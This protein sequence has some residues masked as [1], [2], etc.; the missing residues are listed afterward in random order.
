MSKIK[1]KET[2]KKSNPAAIKNKSKIHSRKK[3]GKNTAIQS[4]N[5]NITKLSDK[6][7][8]VDRARFFSI[9]GLLNVRKNL[10]TS[11]LS[12]IGL[13][14]L[15]AATVV[16]I[17]DTAHNQYVLTFFVDLYTKT[18]GDSSEQEYPP[19]PTNDTKP[20]EP[21]PQNMA[22]IPGG[23]FWMGSKDFNHP[24]SNPIHKV[25]VDA[26][27][28][29]ETEVTN[30]MWAE[31]VEATDY[32]TV[33]ERKPD[34]RLF[35][36]L[37]PHIIKNKAPFSL[38]FTPPPYPVKDLS[39]HL[40]W[41]Q[42]VDGA[43]WKHPEGPKSDIKE[44]KAHPVVQICWIDAV[45]Y[46]NWR[47]QKA[48][49]Q[50]CYDL[51]LRKGD[52]SF[53]A[54]T[55]KEAAQLEDNQLGD[56]TVR[57]P[58]DFG[59]RTGFRLPTEAEWEFAARGGMN[60]KKFLWGDKLKPDGKCLANIWQG[61]FPNQNS[62]KDGFIKAA[63]VKTYPANKFG[64][65]DMAGNVWEWCQDYYQ[66]EYYKDSPEKNPKGP[67]TGFDP[68]EPGIP[69]RV[70]RGGSFLCHE[71]YCERYLTYARGKGEITSAANHIGFRCVRAPQMEA[72]KKDS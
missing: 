43:D 23:W 44:K 31:F 10:L 25:Y 49:L 29:D 53:E 36:D 57:V 28:M 55:L 67:E 22:W 8:N 58:D 60:Q 32:K 41:W 7:A 15:G 72:E 12:L 61:Q 26:F 70:Q 35:P 50:T 1:N 71:S 4:K 30:A 59:K 9:R 52:G 56:L 39:K 33:A 2:V 40:Q 5:T 19:L 63:P 64:L 68:L 65:F 20:N 16:V 66:P 54:I 45:L 42:A 47:S 3:K 38:V 37:P 46:C 69:K 62:K 18:F 13:L 6:K 17:I 24:D 11:Y 48:D 14:L 34:P 21:A 27:W 51:A